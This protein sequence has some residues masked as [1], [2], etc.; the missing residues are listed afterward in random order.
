MMNKNTRH[1]VKHSCYEC[2]IWKR[3]PNKDCDNGYVYL[4]DAHT[5]KVVERV[6]CEVCDGIGEIEEC[7]VCGRVLY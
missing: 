2:A 3:C 1:N 5:G 6:T 7:A 4:V